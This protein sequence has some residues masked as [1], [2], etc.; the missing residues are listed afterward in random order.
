MGKRFLQIPGRG[1]GPQLLPGAAAVEG[2]SVH[3]EAVADGPGDGGKAEAGAEAAGPDM[4]AVDQPGH[5]LPGVV[6]GLAV[7]G[8][9]FFVYLTSVLFPSNIYH[10]YFP[11][12]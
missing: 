3:P 10:G 4:P 7:G 2:G 1:S 8:V 11:F 5:I 9:A 12:T 6:G